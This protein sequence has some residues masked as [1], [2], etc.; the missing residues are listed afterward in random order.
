M[1][2]AALL[3]YLNDNPQNSND[4]QRPRCQET[5]ENVVVCFFFN[6]YLHFPFAKPNLFADTRGSKKYREVLGLM[7]DNF[8]LKLMNCS[9][10]FI[11]VPCQ[12]QGCTK[13]GIL[14]TGLPAK[15]RFGSQFLTGLFTQPAK[16]NSL[17]SL[18][19][20]HWAQQ[21]PVNLT[22]NSQPQNSQPHNSQ[23]ASQQPASLTTLSHPN[24]RQLV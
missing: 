1:E 13:S 20:S 17:A 3:E 2:F 10:F 6:I 8:S 9:P 4:K 7:S 23:P 16:S 5:R 15:Q 14:V 18:N 24:S 11:N 22:N 19:D 21:Q 12:D